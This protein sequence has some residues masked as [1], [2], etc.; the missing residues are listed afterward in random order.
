[1]TDGFGCK[2]D[3][4]IELKHWHGRKVHRV[5][6]HRLR[7]CFDA[8]AALILK[9]TFQKYLGKIKFFSMEKGHLFFIYLIL[10]T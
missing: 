5:G 9:L 4:K 1:M 2:W 8:H 6:V 7:V 10:I 3:H